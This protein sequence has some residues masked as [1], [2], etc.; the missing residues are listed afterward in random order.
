MSNEEL[1][2]QIIFLKNQLKRCR[3]DFRKQALKI[4]QLTNTLRQYSFPSSADVNK[5]QKQT[6]TQSSDDS[7]LSYLSDNEFDESFGPMSAQGGR[8]KKT[9]RKKNRNRKKRTKK[10]TKKS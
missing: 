4:S 10:K 2:E 1:K 8:K 9:K 7:I 3:E 6:L 5:S